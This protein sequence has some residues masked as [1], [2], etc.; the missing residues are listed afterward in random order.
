MDRFNMFLRAA[1]PWIVV[2]LLYAVMFTIRAEMKKKDGQNADCGAEGMSLGICLGL[3][4]EVSFGDNSGMG[5]ALGMLIGLVVG[6][7]IRKEE[8][9]ETHDREKAEPEAGK[10]PEGLI[11]RG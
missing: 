5:I 9:D 2:G 10:R 6:T 1:T 11:R 4:L 8:G 3:C 7:C